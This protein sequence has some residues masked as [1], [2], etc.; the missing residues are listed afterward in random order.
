MLCFALQRLS[1]SFLAAHLGA[2]IKGDKVSQKSCLPSNAAS[3]V[4]IA[5]A[6][7]C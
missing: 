5:I 3:N 7:M 2:L 4:Q 1:R 6:A